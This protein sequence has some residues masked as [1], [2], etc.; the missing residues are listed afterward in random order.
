MAEAGKLVVILHP[1][2]EKP[3]WRWI[4]GGIIAP[5]ILTVGGLAWW[6]PWHRSFEPPSIEHI[7]LAFPDKPF[8]AVQPFASMSND[9]EEYFSDAITQDRSI[10]AGADVVDRSGL[11]VRRGQRAMAEPRIS[12]GTNINTT[13]LKA[14]T[15]L[16]LA[17]IHGD[18]DLVQLLLANGSDVNAKSAVGSFHGET[19]LHSVAYA[20]HTQVAELLLA[21]GAS[22]NA[23]DQ[24]SYTPLR[25]T[26][27]QGHLAMTELLIKKGADI[28]AKDTN[29]VTLLHV[30][31][32]TDHV[33]IAQLLITDGI[34]INA[35]DSFGFTPLDYAQGG[36]REMAETLEQH[37]ALC[38]IC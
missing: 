24:Y 26:V 1:V 25:R 28:V 20:G 4:T 21:Y 18:F 31:A 5:L 36:E 12:K 16:N 17:V 2:V 23:T 33:A 22:V 30:V 10:S 6:Q 8:I 37:G 3:L 38:T 15:P 14:S 11:V 19:P 13:D 7:P 34:D 32:R 35:M 27:E 9:V 29:G